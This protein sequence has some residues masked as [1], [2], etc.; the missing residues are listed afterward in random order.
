M[1]QY[2]DLELLAE[3]VRR[4]R[5]RLMPAP[6]SRQYASPR[7]E[8]CMGIG[9]DHTADITMGDDDLAVL[10]KFMRAPDGAA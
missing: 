5:D 4:N 7:T 6:K 1:E 3:L 10:M 9:N 2:S 8:V